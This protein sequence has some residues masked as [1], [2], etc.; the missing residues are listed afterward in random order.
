LLAAGGALV[1]ILWL[2]GVAFRRVEDLYR[3]GLMAVFGV[4]FFAFIEAIVFI[5]QRL[6]YI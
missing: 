2:G 4:Y 1:L 3:V 6:G 5:Q